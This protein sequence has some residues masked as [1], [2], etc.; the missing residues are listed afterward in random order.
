[1][2]HHHLDPALPLGESK[3]LHEDAVQQLKGKKL[4]QGEKSPVWHKERSA[5]KDFI[6]YALEGGGKWAEKRALE[7]IQKHRQTHVDA[8]KGKDLS[9][10][11]INEHKKWIGTYDNVAKILGKGFKGQDEFNIYDVK[12]GATKDI[13][14]V[15]KRAYSARDFIL[16]ERGL[17]KK[18]MSGAEKT[19]YEKEIIREAVLDA[20]SDNLTKISQLNFSLYS[21]FFILKK[22]NSSH[23]TKILAILF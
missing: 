2:I 3:G 23:P 17:W 6:I 18:G 4:K 20:E 21:V 10:K 8:L 7:V 19:K 22:S 11:S 9:Q 1:M 16:K 5:E 15:S 14:E 12:A 13:K